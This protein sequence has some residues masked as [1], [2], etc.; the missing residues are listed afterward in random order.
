MPGS[1]SASPWTQRKASVAGAI[2][3]REPPLERGAEARVDGG[4][5]VGPTSAAS[6]LVATTRTAMG[7]RASQN[8]RATALR[9]ASTTNTSAPSGSPSG[10]VTA[11]R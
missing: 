5:D 6:P 4:V 7:E 9:S 8:P 10:A 2:D 1:R 3:E 11:S